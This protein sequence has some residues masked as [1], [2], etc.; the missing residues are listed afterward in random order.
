MSSAIDTIDDHDVVDPNAGP[1]TEQ[2]ARELVRE[3]A[4]AAVRFEDAMQQ[5]FRRRAW[6]PLGYDNPQDLILGEFKDGGLINPRTGK[7]YGRAHIYRMARTALFLHEVSSR[8]G[9]D[10]TELDVAEKAL[11][12]ARENGVDDVTML[13]QI[14]NRVIAAAD[15]GEQPDS[16]AVQEIVES[17]IAEAAGRAPAPAVTDEPIP[18]GAV[19]D[20]DDASS[21]APAAP[22]AMP[23]TSTGDVPLAS[24]GDDPT[25]WPNADPH[26]ERDASADV[27]VDD[28]FGTFGAQ[29]AG[30]MAPDGGTSWAEALAGADDF[31]HFTDT[32]R[33]INDMGR[34]LPEV[35]QVAEKLPEFLDACDDSELTAFSEQLDDVDMLLQE[36]P[37]I[38]EAIR[39][40]QES[41]QERAELM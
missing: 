4:E 15:S 38:R 21:D 30:A 10:A 1:C 40:I 41:A 8:T 35:P 19:S 32:L 37:R 12:A 29:T 11:R 16:D 14:E 2:E 5:I 28:P 20:A 36:I 3:V 9:V 27:N 22:P 33:A 7:P 39:A 23:S 34:K 25:D 31:I 26:H 24:D 6:E 13:T 18:S 17:V